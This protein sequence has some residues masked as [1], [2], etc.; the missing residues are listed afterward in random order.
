MS[1]RWRT[2]EVRE[3]LK[4]ENMTSQN[5]ILDS[6]SPEEYDWLHP[7]LEA[8]ELEQNEIIYHLKEPITAVYFP[9]TCLL[10]LANA[11]ALGR[12]VEVEMTGYE[13][14]SDVS[15]LLGE[16]LPSC[17][18]EVQLSGRAFKLSTEDFL[19]TI[20]RQCSG[21]ESPT[22]RISRW[23]NCRNLLCATAFIR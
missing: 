13:G 18:V 9:T 20:D 4:Q 7:L 3:T 1:V 6:L 22:S 10:S 23:C 8:V 14:I 2:E 5:F 19:M 16:T 21:S 12:I 17:Q 15:L 11:T